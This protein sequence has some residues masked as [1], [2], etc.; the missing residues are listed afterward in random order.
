[1]KSKKTTEKQ[2]FAQKN[3]DQKQTKSVTSSSPY[4]AP[5]MQYIAVAV[6]I[7]TYVQHG[8]MFSVLIQNTSL[9][10]HEPKKL[11]GKDRGTG[12]KNL[13]IFQSI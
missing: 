13:K 12:V 5:H 9:I 1:M 3:P 6:L 2:T 11:F 10:I 7:Q 4:I 8:G